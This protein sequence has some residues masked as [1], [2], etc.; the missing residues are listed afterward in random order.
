MV[1]VVEAVDMEVEALVDVVDG[2][3]YALVLEVVLDVDD[4]LVAEALVVVE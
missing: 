2:V 3:E 4:A 1:V